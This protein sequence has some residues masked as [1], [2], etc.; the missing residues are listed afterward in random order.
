[1]STEERLKETREKLKQQEE[2]KRLQQGHN[3]IPTPTS[4]LTWSMLAKRQRHQAPTSENEEGNSLQQLED[5]RT[6]KWGNRGTRFPEFKFACRI[7]LIYWKGIN[8]TIILIRDNKILQNWF[9]LK[10]SRKIQ[11]IVNFLLQYNAF[12]RIF[13]V[14][15]RGS[16]IV[17]TFSRG[18]LLDPFQRSVVDIG[19]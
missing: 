9:S 1:M 12:C 7:Y 6:R 16:Q 3:Q 11:N 15:L 17:N 13:P 19:I 18:L 10:T 8:L 4:T 5:Q 2:E 14:I